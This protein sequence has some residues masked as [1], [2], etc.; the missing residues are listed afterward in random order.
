MRFPG[1]AFTQ[2]LIAVAVVLAGVMVMAPR[3]S[4]H[5]VVE[6]ITPA[7]GQ[8][9]TSG[10]PRV[11]IRFSEAV[12]LLRPEDL[13]VV[14][15]GGQP[16]SSGGGRV[17]AA[18]ASVAEVPVAPRLPSGTY[19]VRWRVVSADGHIIPGASVFAVGDVPVTPPYLGG[20]GGGSG[21]AVAGRAYA[22]SGE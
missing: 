15:S 18:D 10:P 20:P 14:G 13:T 2:I 19:T 1:Q 11:T 17:L 6:Q 7:D 5:A 4:A 16:A 21:P 12:Q 8:R 22:R 9:L 3:A